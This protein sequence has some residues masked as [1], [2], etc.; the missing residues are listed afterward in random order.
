MEGSEGVL[1]GSTEVEDG[2][3]GL[4]GQGLDHF[5][6]LLL[7]LGREIGGGLVQVVE[8]LLTVVEDDG[9]DEGTGDDH[10]DD[11]QGG[12]PLQGGGIAADND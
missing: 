1:D 12:R 5:S 9:V 11:G 8:G 10:V 2:D 7:G 6:V 3:T 4:D